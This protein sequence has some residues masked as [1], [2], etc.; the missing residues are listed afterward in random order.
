M[1][2]ELVI[3][4]DESDISGR[5]FANFYGGLLVE[6]VHLPEV[7]SRI[8]AVRER[9]HLRDE[10]KWQK[11]SHAYADKYI[12]VMDEVFDLAAEGK[13]KLRVMFTHNYR[14][15]ARLT[16]DQRDMGFFLL[17]YQFVKH[18]F[19]LRHAG[20]RDHRM[21]LRLLF[22]QLPDTLEKRAQFK[23][24]LTA[25]THSQEFRDAG[26][27]LMADAI[28]EVDSKHHPLLQCADVV[29]GAMQFRLNDK[30]KE[31][32]E[33]SRTRGKRTIAKERVYRHILARIKAIYPG[34][35]PGVSTGTRSDL[36]NR[37]HDPYR[38]WLFVSDNAVV[39]PEFAKRT[40]KQP[41]VR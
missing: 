28:A 9:L 24:Y 26:I 34:F 22:D 2:R 18:A 33:G 35:N 39:R 31:K 8:L 3:Y 12:E 11:I 29:L 30:H 38:H 37:W 41:R 40:K 7:E 13:L 25:L 10:V 16:E 1:S 14:S 36:A 6:S 5:H 17:Y 21:R 32:P 15:P 27:D 4:C 20:N 23:G 19:G